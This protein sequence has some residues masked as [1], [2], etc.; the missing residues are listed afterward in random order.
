VVELLGD[1]RFIWA[2]D[3]PHVDASLGVVGTLSERIRRLSAKAQ[4][5]ILGDNAARLYGLR[6]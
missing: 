3:Y 1:D 4:Q 2:S 5:K 6:G